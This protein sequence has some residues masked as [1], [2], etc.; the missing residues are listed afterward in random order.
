M[1]LPVDQLPI[2]LCQN[3]A[4]HS[5]LYTAIDSLEAECLL[6]RSSNSLVLPVPN[7]IYY[8][9]SGSWWRCSHNSSTRALVRDCLN[10]FAPSHPPLRWLSCYA[11][12]SYQ[13]VTALGSGIHRSW[14][15]LECI[16]N[17]MGDWCQC[18]D[19]Q[20]ALSALCLSKQ[21]IGD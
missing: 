18:Y 15:L 21:L 13:D 14:H 10:F 11:H 16:R 8:S 4:I 1:P 2:H 12:Y 6:L 3:L 19:I 5:I 17:V 7:R 9:Q 20:S